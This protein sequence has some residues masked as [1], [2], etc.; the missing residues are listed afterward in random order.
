[1]NHRTTA[2]TMVARAL[3]A[4]AAFLVLGA[5]FDYPDVL[6]HPAA[7]V[8][9]AFRADQGTVT[10]GFALLALGAALMAPVALGV[11]HLTTGRLATAAVVTGVAAALVQVTGLLRWILLVPTLAW[12]AADPSRAEVAGDRF[13]TASR[14]LGTGVG[15]TGGY[16][17]TGAW[18][19][20]VL[21]SLRQRPPRWF[22]ALG[23]LSA[24][25]VLLGVLVPLGVP[26]TDLANF[27]GYVAWS[28][29]LLA[30]AV[31]TWRAAP[32]RDTSARGMSSALT[33]YGQ[34]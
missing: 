29:W 34:V 7:E 22:T 28:A 20:L 30:F 19:L 14:I 27:V 11:R 31:L 3:T 4:N 13:E 5:A 17:L 8:L 10:A 23:V 33:G 26:G 15:E 2:L 1:M 25:L 16:L 6:Q 32:A 21:A 9:A 12:Q 24:V 18:T